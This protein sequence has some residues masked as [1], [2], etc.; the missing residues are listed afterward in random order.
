LDV[1]A[2]AWPASLHGTYTVAGSML[3]WCFLFITCR[4]MLAGRSRR[5]G[6]A[7]SSDQPCAWARGQE[8]MDGFLVKDGETL[9]L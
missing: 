8:A 4:I 7:V 5:P 1:H 9:A 2:D 3:S 6:G